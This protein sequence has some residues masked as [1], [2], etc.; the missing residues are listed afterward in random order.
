MALNTTGNPLGTIFQTYTSSTFAGQV[1]GP[2]LLSLALDLS[3]DA[4]VIGSFNT[5]ASP[6]SFATTVNSAA[7]AVKDAIIFNAYLK[8]KK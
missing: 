5:I 4:T 8:K 6:A 3:Q 1:S 2:S 7:L